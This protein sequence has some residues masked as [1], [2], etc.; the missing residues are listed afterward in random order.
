M[1]NTTCD[2]SQVFGGK[3]A[4]LSVYNS[5]KHWKINELVFQLR[6]LGKRNNGIN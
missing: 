4:A 3:F 2:N 1:K 5:N 6:N